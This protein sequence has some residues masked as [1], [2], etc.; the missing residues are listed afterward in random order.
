MS[1]NRASMSAVM[2]C[3]SV[4][5]LAPSGQRA[6][7]ANAGA[8]R[9]YH[10]NVRFL[11][12]WCSTL[13]VQQW[14]LRLVALHFTRRFI[15]DLARSLEVAC[16]SSTVVALS[17]QLRRRANRQARFVR[18]CYLYHFELMFLTQ[19]NW[20][21]ACSICSG[22]EV[23]IRNH[24]L[25]APRLL[26]TPHIGPRPFAPRVLTTGLCVSV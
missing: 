26:L 11:D 14:Y 23:V 13:L 18:C 3:S 16:S 8:Q 12:A 24:R 1:H 21:S 7:L 17:V 19:S 10:E 2:R 6:V 15:A 5:R 22:C 20:K 25:S 4:L 9:L